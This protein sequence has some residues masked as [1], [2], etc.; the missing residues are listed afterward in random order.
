M[1]NDAHPTTSEVRPDPQ[2]QAAQEGPVATGSAFPDDLEDPPRFIQQLLLEL[3]E[4]SGSDLFL[5]PGFP[6]AMKVD[7]T[8]R[9]ARPKP[10]TPRLTLALAKAIMNDRQMAEFERSNECNFGIAPSGIGRFRVSAFVQQESVSL[11]LRIVPRT[12]PTIESM[13][14]PGVFRDLVMSKRGLII[15]AGATGTGKSTSLAAMLDWRNEHSAGHIQTIEDPIEFVHAHKNCV[16]TQREVGRDAEGWAVALRNSVRQAP[17]VVMIGEIRDRETMEHAVAFAETGHL[18]LT[19]LHANNTNQALDRAIHLIP[20]DRR[21]QL[22]MDLSLN[23][24]AIISQRLL[25]RQDGDGR[26]AAVEVMINSPLVAKH[27]FNGE[28][29]EIR[30]VMKRSRELGMQTFDQALF[31]LYEA[32]TISFE[33]ALRNADSLNDLRLRIKL[34]SKRPD[35]GQAGHTHSLRLV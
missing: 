2:G 13:N 11:V 27:V 32:G 25:A 19:T 15:L 30:E 23:L 22:L 7:G 5:V 1:P 3:V 29:P 14:L 31:D 6:P 8:L 12:I 34:E 26:V 20:K 28:I 18:V 9:K 10:L 4:S 16:V 35:S 33:D 21:A 24:R 17:D